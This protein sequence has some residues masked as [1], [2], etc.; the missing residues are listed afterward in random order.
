MLKR[1]RTRS[2]LTHSLENLSKNLFKQHYKLIT[3]LIGS[4]PGIYALY[5]SNELYYVG[6][7]TDLRKRVKHHLRD[8][9][10]ASWSHFSL[11][12]VRKEDHINEIESL[13][14]RIANPKGNKV[15]PKGKSSSALLKQLKNLVKQ[16]Q[17]REF[18]EMFGKVNSKQTKLKRT[19]VK[20]H[21]KDLVKKNTPL[22]RTYKGNEYK[23]VL[24]PKGIIKLNSNEYTTPTAAAMSVIDRKSVNGWWFWYIKNLDREWVRLRDYKV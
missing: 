23:A 4:S 15:R 11:Y 17:R 24:T 5:D 14:V 9:H 6:K 1:R 19:R 21:L 3:E 7:S 20:R 2:L 16:K 8:R 10:Y 22:Y 13:L 18:A 12:L